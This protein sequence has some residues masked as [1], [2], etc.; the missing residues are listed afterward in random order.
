LETTVVLLAV[1]RGFGVFPG[2]PLAA[3]LRPLRG[4]DIGLEDK[5]KVL[6]VRGLEQI[7][8]FQI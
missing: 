6:F 8:S 7:E 3:L 1:E 4:R 2:K 5:T